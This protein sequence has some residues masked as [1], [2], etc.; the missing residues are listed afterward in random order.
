MTPRGPVALIAAPV[1]D[2]ADGPRWSHN[3]PICLYDGRDLDPSLPPLRYRC[4]A[5]GGTLQ[6]DVA[7]LLTA[8]RLPARE[9]AAWVEALVAAFGLTRRGQGD[10]QAIVDPLGLS[11]RLIVARCGS[12][13]QPLASLWGCGEFQ[14]G[15]E[16]VTYLGAAPCR[17]ASPG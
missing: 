2:G 4:P 15:R 12:C 14:P 8:P 5:C 6:L 17:E 1:T 10:F 11:A 16:V 9:P 7:Q 3:G 13:A